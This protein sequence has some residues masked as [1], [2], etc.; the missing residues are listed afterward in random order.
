MYGTEAQQEVSRR[1]IKIAHDAALVRE[2]WRIAVEAAAEKNRALTDSQVM[3]LR[4][5]SKA[6]VKG[7]DLASYYGISRAAISNIIHRKSYAWVK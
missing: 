5:L 3:S 7:V 4:A 2:T 6:G 1:T